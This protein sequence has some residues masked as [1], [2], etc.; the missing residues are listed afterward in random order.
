VVLDTTQTRLGKGFWGC[1]ISGFVD[2]AGDLV[3]MKLIGFGSPA[4]ITLV[5]LWF[6]SFGTKG[7]GFSDGC[8]I[9]VFMG[10]HFPDQR[11]ALGWF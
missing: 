1:S 7:F 6:R 2:G 11:P 10:R 8:E 9:F 5:V 4:L 3:W